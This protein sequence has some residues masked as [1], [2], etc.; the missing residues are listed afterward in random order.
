MGRS[1]WMLL[2]FAVLAV[3]GYAAF[4]IFNGDA[5]NPGVIVA[6]LFLVAHVLEIP[7]AALALRGMNASWFKT[8]FGTLIF[9]FTW[10]IPAKKG[11]YSV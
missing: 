9:G 5:L 6:V 2:N 10:W 7:I 1:F 4:C 3:Y 11:L 8:I